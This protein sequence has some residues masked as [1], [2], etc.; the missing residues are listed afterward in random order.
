[1][2]AAGRVRPRGVPRVAALAATTASMTHQSVLGG[3][4]QGALFLAFG[5][6]G[7]IVA[8][9]QP[10][11]PMGWTLLGIPLCFALYWLARSYALLDYRFHRGSLPLGWVAVLLGEAWAPVFVLAGLVGRR[12]LYLLRRDPGLLAGLADQPG[13]QLPAGSRRAPLAAQVAA[14]RGGGVSGQ[15]DRAVRR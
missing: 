13:D 14:Q 12:H 2:T 11:N 6:I 3:L 5:L 1:M 15:R 10:R 8:W 9:H 7:A 4:D